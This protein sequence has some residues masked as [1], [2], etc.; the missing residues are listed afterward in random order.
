MTPKKWYLSKGIWAGIIAVA[1]AVYNSFHA[2]MLTEF[3][4]NLPVIPDWIFPILA[5]LGLYGRA[6]ANT[7]ITR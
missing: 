1:V 6:T 5:A 3:N 7:T 2:G 4:I